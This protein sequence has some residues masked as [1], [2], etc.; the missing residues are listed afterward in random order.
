MRLESDF[1]GLRGHVRNYTFICNVYI[2]Y[3]R[4]GQSRYLRQG[5]HIVRSLI[6]VMVSYC[7]YING[8]RAVFYDA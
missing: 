6:N 5:C 4:H 1:A 7:R 8:I 2:P 3:Y